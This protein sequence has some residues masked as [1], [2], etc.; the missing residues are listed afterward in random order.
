RGRP[1]CASG[2][3]PAGLGEDLE[4]NDLSLHRTQDASRREL[5]FTRAASANWD[6]R[7]RTGGRR[8][9]APPRTPRPKDPSAGRTPGDCGED[10]D[11]LTIRH[12]GLDALAEADVLPC[13]EDVDEA[14][15][16]P[17][18]HHPG[19]EALVTR[20]ELV[21]QLADGSGR[22]LHGGGIADQGPQR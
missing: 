4:S 5:Q 13:D 6:R 22:A 12:G 9:L 11:L 1:P 17:V 16:A 20:V 7:R 3:T 14:A 18:L 2:G 10:G 19:P 15:E 21:D 8:T